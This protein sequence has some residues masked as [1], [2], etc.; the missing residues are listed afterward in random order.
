[1]FLCGRPRLVDYP[2]L[3]T[4]L[5][6][7]ERHALANGRE[8]IRHANIESAH[9]DCATAVCGLM[10]TLDQ[11]RGVIITKE[12]M[13]AFRRMPPRHSGARMRYRGR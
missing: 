13:D 10:V 7:L 9:D 8:T 3:R 2:T 5:A 6:G 4:Q 11:N 1:M 12:M